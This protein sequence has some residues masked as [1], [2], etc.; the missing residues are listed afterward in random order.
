MQPI[1]F[2]NLYFPL[3]SKNQVNYIKNKTSGS[4]DRFVLSPRKSN[5]V[6][7]RGADNLDK[8]ESLHPKE[9]KKI[10]SI[11]ENLYE[12]K[13]EIKMVLVGKKPSAQFVLP[14]N[15][16]CTFKKYKNLFESKDIKI[17]LNSKSETE[18]FYPPGHAAYIFNIPKLKEVVD[19][20]IDFY[21]NWF[22]D[23][24]LTNNQ[25]IKKLTGDESPL[26]NPKTQHDILGVTLGFPLADSLLFK[27]ELDIENTLGLLHQRKTTY[28]V[29]ENVLSNLLKLIRPD[30]YG[31]ITT[32]FKHPDIKSSDGRIDPTTGK[33]NTYFIFTTWDK[34]HNEARKIINDDLEAGIKETKELFPS[35]ED[36]LFYML[37]KN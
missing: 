30:M 29:H 24:K 11:L 5:F 28:P 4:E 12:N 23:K 7:F 31:K 15:E 33:L 10:A 27:I 8:F 37:T 21:R 36:F 14:K 18:E 25:I 22:D 35:F 1:N 19:K 17:I 32:N 2:Q 20:N 9:Q 34:E 3:Q 16:Y 26:L 13:D 6:A